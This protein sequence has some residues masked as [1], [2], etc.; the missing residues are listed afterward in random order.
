MSLSQ[1]KPSVG[2]GELKSSKE[3]YMENFK[4]IQNQF[5]S[6]REQICKIMDDYVQHV[7]ECNK[8]SNKVITKNNWK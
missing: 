2:P 6:P 3:F 1:Q 4:D 7:L 5:S 8:I